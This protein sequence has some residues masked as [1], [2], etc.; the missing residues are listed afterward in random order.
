MTFEDFCLVK[1]IKGLLSGIEDTATNLRYNLA[2]DNIDSLDVGKI[3]ALINR[4]EMK[5]NEHKHGDDYW[6]V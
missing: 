2:Y 5:V 4:I 3:K 1:E 6:D